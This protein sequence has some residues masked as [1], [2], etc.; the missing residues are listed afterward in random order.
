V[1]LDDATRRE[2]LKDI[3]SPQKHKD[4]QKSKTFWEQKIF[5]PLYTTPSCYSVQRCQR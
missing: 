2:T 1:S 4:E 5:D 3:A